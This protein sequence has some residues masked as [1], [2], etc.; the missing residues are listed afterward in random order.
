MSELRTI[1]EK[2]KVAKGPIMVQ[3]LSLKLGK[4]LNR[5][6]AEN[7]A[8]DGASLDKLKAEARLLGVAL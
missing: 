3:R 8:L 4:D 7:G 5:L 2:V 6:V 1:I